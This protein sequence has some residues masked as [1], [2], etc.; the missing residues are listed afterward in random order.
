VGGTEGERESERDETP[1][2]LKIMATKS[3]NYI[4]ILLIMFYEMFLK[5]TFKQGIKRIWT[6]ISSNWCRREVVVLFPLIL[7]CV[8]WFSQLEIG[9]THFTLVLVNDIFSMVLIV[10]YCV[11]RFLSRFLT[12]KEVGTNSR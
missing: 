7:S 10:Y 5:F 4:L 9:V 1:T 3:G 8:L 11:S 2:I 6:E 12:G